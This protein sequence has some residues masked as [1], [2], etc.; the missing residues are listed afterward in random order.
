[1]SVIIKGMKMPRDCEECAIKSWDMEDY[2]C[3][4]SGVSTLC[5][6]RQ[7]N[8]PLIEIPPHGRLID[9][10]ALETHHGWYAPDK[11]RN[12]VQTHIQFLYANDVINAP[13][14]IEADESHNERYDFLEF[15]WNTINPNE[16]Q[17]YWTMFH[18]KGVA[19]NGEAEDG[20]T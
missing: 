14:V 3:P 9:A 17:E 20:E 2:V 12:V 10:D 5:I 16:M 7:A 19:T 18:C 15:L 11:E 4:F 13:T 6:S 8:C 1:M